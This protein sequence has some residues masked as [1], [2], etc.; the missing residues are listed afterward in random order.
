MYL[1]WLAP[2]A[3]YHNPGSNRAPYGV[4]AWQSYGAASTSI[5]ASQKKLSKAAELEGWS[6]TDRGTAASSRNLQVGPRMAAQMDCDD[7][8][9]QLKE[10]ERQRLALED[11]AAAIVNELDGLGVGLKDAL[12]DAEGYPRADLDLYRVRSQRGRHA[13]IRTDHKALMKK[14]EVLLPIALAA[15]P[16]DARAT[17]PPSRSV[18][19]PPAPPSNAPWCS[20]TEVRDG[21]PAAE[22]GLRLG[23][24]VVAFG[25][26]ISLDQVKPFVL[27]HVGRPFAVWVERG[28]SRVKLDMTARTWAGEGLLGCRLLPLQ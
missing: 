21:S 28:S 3:V 9:S 24:L 27:G 23:D 8:R 5:D 25:D 12:V 14:I 20:I 4:S 18:K 19:P 11:E 13:T 6:K 22:A 17:P 26:A 1:D 7:A 15:P 2:L 10:L 16:E